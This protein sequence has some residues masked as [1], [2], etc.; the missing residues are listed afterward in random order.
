MKLF[1]ISLLLSVFLVG[2][3]HIAKAQDDGPKPSI[4]DDEASI[5]NI[6]AV[7]AQG[8]RLSEGCEAIRRRKTLDAATKPWRAIGRVNFASTQLRH[9]C[10]GTLVSEKVVL[11]AAHCLYNFPRKT[12]LPPQSIIFVAGFQRGSGVAVSR[13]E[14]FVFDKAVQSD[15]RDFRAALEQD[16]ALIVL[17]KPIGKDA[18]YLDTV[19]LNSGVS[20]NA[21]FMVAGYSGL[22]PNVLSLALDCGWPAIGKKGVFLQS[23]SVMSGD[24]GAPLLLLQEG[25]YKVAGVLS[26][27]AHSGSGY[28]TLLIPTAFF[29]DALRVQIKGTE[30]TQ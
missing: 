11:T 30:V 4:P 5:P 1:I 9:H 12:W 2:G 8:P 3:V 14:R 15:S 17:K 24:S 18:G 26:G 6:E 20:D 10:T 19:N 13:G 29:E 27:I 21:D 22:R 16:W 23:C 7:C 28:T 25:Q